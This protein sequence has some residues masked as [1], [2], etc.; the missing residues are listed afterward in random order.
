MTGRKFSRAQEPV[1][2][3]GPYAAYVRGTTKGMNV[4]ILCF[5]LDLNSHVGTYGLRAGR[6]ARPEISRRSGL[7]RPRGAP[8]HRLFA[9]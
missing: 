4:Y 7:P 8:S 3:Y 2:I 1:L 9:P 5:L 6:V